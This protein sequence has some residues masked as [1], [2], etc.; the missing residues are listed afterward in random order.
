MAHDVYIAL[1]SNLGDREANILGGMQAIEDLRETVLVRRSSVIETD[2]VG[3]AGQGPYLN[4]AVHARP[5]FSPRGL[6][7][8]LLRIEGAFGRE[9]VSG[10]RWGPRTLDLDILLYDD[11][12]ID[13]PGLSV[14]HP[15]LSERTFVL[16]PLAEIAPELSIPGHKETPRGMLRALVNH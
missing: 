11:Q 2:P 5:G 4:A 16:V 15:R 1:G 14:P 7:D 10:E 12:V 8:E 13:E 6:L 3:P 9:R